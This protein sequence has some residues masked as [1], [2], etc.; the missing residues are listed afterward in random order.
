MR[1]AILIVLGMAASVTRAI[2]PHE[3]PVTQGRVD[4]V[5][6]S[7]GSD[8]VGR[9]LS[10]IDPSSGFRRQVRFENRSKM[11]SESARVDSQSSDSAASQP[12]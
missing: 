4:A 7:A 9:I 6:Q 12:P 11:T 8:V 5:T 2:E 1:L 3:Y 10:S